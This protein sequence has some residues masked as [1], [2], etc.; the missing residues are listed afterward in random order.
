MS[1][2]DNQPPAAA[3]PRPGAP[4]KFLEVGAEGQLELPV[5]KAGYS[6]IAFADAVR[7]MGMGLVEALQMPDGDEKRRLLR[8][9]RKQCNQLTLIS[10]GHRPGMVK[11]AHSTDADKLL[12]A[13]EC[14]VGCAP[15]V[16][17][18]APAALHGLGVEEMEQDGKNLQYYRD[19]QHDEERFSYGVEVLITNSEQ[20]LDARTRGVYRRVKSLMTESFDFGHDLKALQALITESAEEGVETRK[21]LAKTRAEVKDGKGP[22]GGP[23][24]T[25]PASPTPGG[26]GSGDSGKTRP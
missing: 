1:V 3:A 7:H 26:T 16:K 10:L 8:H 25:P 20:S 17:A 4:P 23:P 5:D 14:I 15:V 2:R 12:P 18:H 11:L 13:V 24:P 22:E 21:R 6:E 9:Y 19:V